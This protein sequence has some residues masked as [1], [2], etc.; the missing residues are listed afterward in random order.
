MAV[1]FGSNLDILDDVWAAD[2]LPQHDIGIEIID[3]PVIVD[4]DGEGIF[5]S[6]A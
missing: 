5:E 6:K 3:K 4:E 1:G 2:K